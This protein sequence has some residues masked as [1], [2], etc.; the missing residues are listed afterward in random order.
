ML[1]SARRI[2]LTFSGRAGILNRSGRARSS[3]CRE[4]CPMSAPIVDTR[5]LVS[6]PRALWG[7]PRGDTASPAVRTAYEQPLVLPQLPQT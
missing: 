7:K 5:H 6:Y 1:S 2:S 3:D 4:A